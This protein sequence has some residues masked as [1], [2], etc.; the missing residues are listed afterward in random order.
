MTAL[1]IACLVFVGSHFLLSHPLRAWLVARLGAQGFL[2]VYSLVALGSF[3]WVI[4]A[5]G[6][7][8]AT[9]PA[10][11]PG[12]AGWAVASLVMWLASVLFAGSLIGNP[13][14]PAPGAAQAAMRP[15]A[16][17]FA[18]TRHPMMWGFALWAIVHMALWPTPENHILS[19]AILLLALG[20]SAGQDAKKAALLGDAWRG[21]QA[22]TAFVP[23]AGQLSGR[24]SWRAAWPGLTVLVAG[25]TLWLAATW[26]HVPLG[27]RLAAG[28]WRWF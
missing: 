6:R 4:H 23:F 24:I 21:W 18:I 7:V 12:D 14:L 26:A 11:I 17:V 10:Y 28:I 15:P 19:S 22:G 25:T 3:G 8:P 2:G 9:N 13:A 16:G 5:F 1:A 20:G 27:A